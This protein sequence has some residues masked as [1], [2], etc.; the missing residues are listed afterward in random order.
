MV[1]KNEIVAVNKKQI[2]VSNNSNVNVVPYLFNIDKIKKPNCKLCQS[3]FREKAEQMYD[4]QKRKNYS[5]IK[6][7]LKEEDDFDIS[8]HAV[9]NHL[10]YHYKISQNN[11]SLQ[12]YAEN[13]Q[14]WVNMQT[15][16]V[17]AFRSRIAILEREMFTIAEAGEDL[18]IIER[19]K[20]AETVKKLAEIILIY[21]DKLNEFQQEVKPVNLIFNQLKIIV[22]DELQHIENVNTKRIL[23]TVLSR[24]KESVGEMII[25]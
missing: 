12:E 18:D 19:R 2:I 24:L 4:D 7:K 9:K 16:R 13:V 11:L 5:A 3:E 6:N 22:N 23:S 15:N 17:A 10:L 14:Q 8:N 1:K 20:N 21:E 25:E